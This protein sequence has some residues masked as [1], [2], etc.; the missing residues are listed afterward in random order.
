[1]SAE[2]TERPAPV[3]DDKGPEPYEADSDPGGDAPAG[4]EADRPQKAWSARRDLRDHS[5]RSM[6]FGDG[7]AFGGS[8]VGGDQHGVSGGRVAGD[9]IMGGKTEIHYRFGPLGEPPA[10]SGE[11]PAERLGRLAE[12]FVDEETNFQGLAERLRRDHVLVLTG[13]RHSGRWTAALML[14]HGLGVGSVRALDR[15]TT[16]AGLAGQLDHEGTG[17]HGHVLRDPLIR[18]DAPLRETHLLAA[19]ARLGEHGY[20]V[21][22]AGPNTALDGVR[23]HPW[24]PPAPHRVL[25][26][27]LSALVGPERAARLMARPEVT[28]FLARG[29][30]VREAALYAA[31]LEK[32]LLG[33]VGDT[34]IAGFSL[35]T[36]EGQVQ[37]WFEADEH[38]VHL[39]DKAFL[40]ALAAFDGGPYALTAELSDLLY[41]LLQHT[42]NPGVYPTVP[43][44][45][46][47]I[48]KRLQLARAH[49]YREKEH[50]EW[51][52][53]TQSKAAYLDE[54]AA[55]VLLREVWTGHPSARPALVRWLQQLADDGRPL[56]RTRAA[57]TAAVLA[58]TDLPSA[59]AL[60][61][62]AWAHSKTYRRRLVA[63]NALALAHGL[64]TPNVPRILDGWCQGDEPGPAWV[65]VRAHALIGPGRPE[66]TLTALRG[67]ARKQY[68]RGEEADELMLDELA[69]AVSLLLLSEAGDRVLAEL[70][71]TLDD[72]RAV[73]DMALAG[74]IGAC[75]HTGEDEGDGRPLVLAWYAEAAAESAGRGIAT[76]WRRALGDRVHTRTALDVLRDWVLLADR[77]RA[78]EWALAA[79]L[80]ALAATATEH[81]RLSHLLRTMPGED[82]AP[83]PPV[84]GRLQ[85]ALTGAR[86]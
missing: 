71:R 5:P 7:A 58:R 17:A 31:E 46:T 33:R 56:V 59:M 82:G 44:F 57:S 78:T 77:E 64:D 67:A 61:I 6:R 19:R 60:V 81:Q 39:R 85:R 30:Q 54:R 26:S 24:R 49:G 55:L 9:V 11:I 2:T 73:Q 63:A 75:R 1:M 43:V 27:S 42:E 23:G 35:A 13:P 72:D 83:P 68:E 34:E 32:H 15:E 51:G 40:I 48:G 62:E 52:P 10:A 79:L 86:V 20:L 28:G 45:G 16:P 3:P 80:P 84:T 18:R 65:A 29:H 76:L 47:H 14:L 50:T 12:L 74:F 36:L 22:T 66:E 4:E 8:L 70:L 53:V 25:E 41:A 69:D 37:E 38:T 21:V